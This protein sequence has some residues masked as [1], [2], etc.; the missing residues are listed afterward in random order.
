MHISVVKIIGIKIGKHRFPPVA[1]LAEQRLFITP[2]EL[3][4]NL[5][6]KVFINQF[7]PAHCAAA[8]LMQKP[9]NLVAHQYL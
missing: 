4:G 5:W 2:P 8:V 6:I 7:I 9:V 1:D 3:D